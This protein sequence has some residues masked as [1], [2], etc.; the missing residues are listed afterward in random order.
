[1]AGPREDSSARDLCPYGDFPDQ[2]RLAY[3]RLP[4]DQVQSAVTLGSAYGVRE[5]REEV[6]TAN[7]PSREDP[8]LGCPVR[9]GIGWKTGEPAKILQ[10]LERAGVTSIRQGFE[11]SQ[12][13]A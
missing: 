12:G 8:A 7:E 4:G 6:F 1:V 3:P 11:E 2:A 10:D 5:L 9:L 13:H